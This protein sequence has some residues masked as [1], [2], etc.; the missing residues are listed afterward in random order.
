MQI[1]CFS[2]YACPYCYIGEKRLERAMDELGV[3][4][5]VQIKLRAFELDPTAPKTVQSDTATRFASKYRLSIADA[6]ARIEHI[7]QLGREEGLDFQYAKSQYTNTFDAHRLMK[8]ALSKNNMEIAHKTNTYLFDAYFT[9][10]LKLADAATLLAVAELAG[11]DVRETEQML[12]S[13]EFGEAVRKDEEEAARLGIHGVP[14]FIFANGLAIPGAASTEDF[15]K[16]LS[17]NL[18]FGKKPWSVH[19]CGPDGCKL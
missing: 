17:E 6:E 13:G 16:M 3:K 10:S 5:K 15:K 8:F 1:V 2:D 12:A 19:S 14:Y 4:D 7:S 18:G 11:L 9:K